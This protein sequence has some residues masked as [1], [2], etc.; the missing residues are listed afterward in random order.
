LRETVFWTPPELE[1]PNEADEIN[2]SP[3]QSF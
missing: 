3:M 2:K 1:A